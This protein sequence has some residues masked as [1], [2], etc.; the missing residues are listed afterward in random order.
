MAYFIL[1]WCK[2][3]LE[4]FENLSALAANGYSP[5]LP[6]LRYDPSTC[7]WNVD[8][9]LIIRAILILLL[10]FKHGNNN[11]VNKKWPK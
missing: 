1:R 2:I 3:S 8:A 9:T 10:I 4:F 6:G 7:P 11:S 5:L